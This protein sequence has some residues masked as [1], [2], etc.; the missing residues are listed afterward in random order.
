MSDQVLEAETPPAKSAKGADTV[1]GSI[2]AIAVCHGLNDMMQSL[3]PAIYPEFKANFGLSFGQIGLVT[4]CYQITASILQPLI[5]Y[6]A[7]KRP[8]PMALPGGALFSLV[9]LAIL[10]FAHSCGVILV[11]AC[12][13]GIGSAVVQPE[14]AR[15][16]G[17]AA[18]PRAGVPSCV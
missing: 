14:S 12:I 6:Y 3:L 16:A 13:L 15:V 5:G 7:D 18:R 4:L 1:C 8:T 17:M 11:G 2:A 10:S 9:G